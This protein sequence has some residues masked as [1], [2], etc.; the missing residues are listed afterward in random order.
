MRPRRQ[1]LFRQPRIAAVFFADFASPA[2]FLP[3]LADVRPRSGPICVK[4]TP[5]NVDLTRMNRRRPLPSRCSRRRRAS[6]VEQSPKTA[7]N[8]PCSARM[9]TPNRPQPRW[10]PPRRQP[11]QKELPP[12]NQ[13]RWTAHPRPRGREPSPPTTH[14]VRRAASITPFQD[15]QCH[16]ASSGAKCE[17]RP[18]KSRPAP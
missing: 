4:P 8:H 1:K 16:Y 13:T 5:S 17:H 9:P 10:K 3:K 18:R 11:G 2:G 7:S 14:Q 12:R 6:A 15:R